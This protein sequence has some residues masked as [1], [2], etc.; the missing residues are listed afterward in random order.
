MIGQLFGEGRRDVRRKKEKKYIL[1]LKRLKYV[2]G[3]IAEKVAAG[4][5]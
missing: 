2:P 3:N 1:G 4:I 5:P